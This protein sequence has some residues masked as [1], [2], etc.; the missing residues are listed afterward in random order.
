[1]NAIHQISLKLQLGIDPDAR[2]APSTLR[3]MWETQASRRLGPAATTPT[4]LTAR[5]AAG[6]PIAVP[7]PRS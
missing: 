3:A 4:K 5:D 2:V 1:M 6:R 7:A